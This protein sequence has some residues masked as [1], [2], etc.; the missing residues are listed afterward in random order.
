MPEAIRG[1]LYDYGIRAAGQKEN[2]VSK[3]PEYEVKTSKKS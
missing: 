1:H 3:M 2:E